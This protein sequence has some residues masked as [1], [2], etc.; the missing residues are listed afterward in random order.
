MNFKFI[1]RRTR[2]L[3]RA[4]CPSPARKRRWPWPSDAVVG[5][6]VLFAGLLRISAPLPTAFSSSM[7][8][9]P[10]HSSL[11]LVSSSNPNHSSGSCSSSSILEKLSF[12]LC[13]LCSGGTDS[14]REFGERSGGNLCPGSEVESARG[15][16]SI[17]ESLWEEK[18]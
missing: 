6:A 1:P 12:C 7:S 14:N 4:K 9:P 5:A 13:D 11:P 16:L 18:G 3:Q 10:S 2:V 15:F 17:Q 8:Y